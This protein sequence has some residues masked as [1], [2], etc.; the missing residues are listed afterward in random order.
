MDGN[1]PRLQSLQIISLPKVSNFLENLK[2][3]QYLALSEAEYDDL[4]ELAFITKL[5]M[6]KELEVSEPLKRSHHFVEKLEYALAYNDFNT[7]NLF[8]GGIEESLWP[9]LLSST[10]SA[11]GLGHK[12]VATVYPPQPRPCDDVFRPL[13]IPSYRVAP[14]MKPH[15][16]VYRL[17]QEGQGSFAK[18]LMHRGVKA[19][20]EEE[21][22]EEEEAV[23][24]EEVKEES[25]ADRW[26]WLGF[27]FGQSYC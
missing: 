17:L 24:E 4:S 20:A 5:P 25:D 18:V 3:L 23:V 26:K 7:L 11:F 16:V 19:A 13:E 1:L 22:E 10:T 14:R 21:E 12:R 6:L 15:D 2:Q 8:H 27:T 9:Q